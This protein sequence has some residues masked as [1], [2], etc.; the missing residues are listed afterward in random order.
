MQFSLL[1]ILF[2]A[3]NPPF[4]F[5]NQFGRK[6]MTDFAKI[7]VTA[8]LAD[9]ERPE[10]VY[11]SESMLKVTQEVLHTTDTP[12]S[13]ESITYTPHMTAAIAPMSRLPIVTAYWIWLFASVASA[14]TAMVLIL[15]RERKLGNWSTTIITL[16]I[17]GSINSMTVL[18]AGQTTWYMFLFFCITY[19]GLS[20]RKDWATGIGFALAT[21]KP[22][23]SFLFFA[24]L[25]AEKRWR[26]LIIFSA[27]VALM[28]SYA[29]LVIGWEN[30]INYP[31][32]I[33]KNSTGDITW[34]P[35]RMCNLRALLC[36]LMPDQI[37]YK[38]GFGITVLSMPAV[39]KLWSTING[40]EEKRR[41]TFSITMLLALTLGPHVNCYDCMLVGI[42]AILTL[43]SA[44]L[45][46]MWQLESKPYRLWCF[47]LVAYAV[48]GWILGSNNY[49]F[50]P[51][52]LAL[53][54]CGL[55]HLRRIEK[56]RSA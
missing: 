7:Y 30:V 4:L 1:S 14:V 48:F 6:S 49:V 2:I 32:I 15:K 50:I 39:Y 3:P 11:D 12:D 46:D 36:Y 26:A 17:L 8:K 22:Q 24:G 37:A 19:I 21:I 51:L 10:K 27:M 45:I 5:P 54:I 52:N 29:G 43:P 44:S 38:I 20:R 41:W 33:S 13:S 34:F 16:T 23:Y 9:S 31:A 28:L 18:L 35:H 47:L 55:M 25:V 53:T 42:P 56:N 40:N